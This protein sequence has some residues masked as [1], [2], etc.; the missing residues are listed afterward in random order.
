MGLQTEPQPDL[1][2][3]KAPE[4][5]AQGLGLAKLL[6]KHQEVLG[7]LHG[8]LDRLQKDDKRSGPNRVRLTDGEGEAVV[9]LNWKGES[10]RWLLTVY[11]M[12]AEAGTSMD[13][14]SNDSKDDTARLEPGS[15]ASVAQSSNPAQAAVATKPTNLKEGIAKIQA[16][17]QAQSKHNQSPESETPPILAQGKGSG[18]SIS[19]VTQVVDDFLAQF[20]HQAPVVI[21]DSAVGV[22][23]GASNNDVIA[24]AVHRGRIHL[25]LD[26]IPSRPEA[27]KTLWHE[28]L[29][30]GLRRFLTKDQFTAE[31]TAL[32]RS[33][34]WVR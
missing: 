29:H 9:S 14:A 18:A 34:M 33:D 20:A 19:E 23:P 12:G 21:A 13:T 15:A 27:I 11:E 4:G 7:D 3:G 5:K 24:G 31:M 16:Q 6:V 22:L 25:F 2:W 30:Y 1:V 8:F 28:L 32:Y 26:Q 17:K 10:K